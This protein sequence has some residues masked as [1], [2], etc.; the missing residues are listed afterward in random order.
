MKYKF[1]K[2]TADLKFQAFGKTKEE[3]FTNSFLALRS[4]IKSNLAKPEVEKKIKIKGRDFENLMYK[5]LEEVLFL[6]DSEGFLAN[7][8]SEI[9]L[10]NKNNTITAKL[11]G[12]FIEGCKIF[13]DIKAVTYSEM[14]ISKVKGIWTAQ[15]VLDV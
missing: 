5:F 15:V 9:K 1:L 8:I 13:N 10:D 3:M 6:L 2:H 7:K 4:V 12:Q 11:S 14:K